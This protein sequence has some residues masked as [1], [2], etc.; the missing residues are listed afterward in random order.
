MNAKRL[1][2]ALAA[3]AVG[4]PAAVL[5]WPHMESPGATAAQRSVPRFAAAHLRSP[6][7]KPAA[8]VTEAPLLPPPALAAPSLQQA[9]A[10]AV[11]QLV[12]SPGNP[13]GMRPAEET[14]MSNWAAR[15]PEAAG[16]WLNQNR[17]HPKFA[18]L[19]R[20]YAIQIETMG[21]GE[22]RQWAA[23]IPAGQNR[24]ARGSTLEQHIDAIEQML[25]GPASE[26]SKPAMGLADYQPV[27]VRQHPDEEPVL[28]MQPVSPFT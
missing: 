11:P 12:W 3:A 16:H 20:G 25:R 18:D 28:E 4:I 26:A 22:A 23:Q 9:V 8:P 19:V 15:D 13:Y 1:A 10:T 21:P 14:M 24:F 17:A 6:Q 5:L 27:L 7:V 2:L